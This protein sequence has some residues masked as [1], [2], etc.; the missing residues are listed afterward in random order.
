MD[1]MEGEEI[2]SGL[3]GRGPGDAGRGGRTQGALPGQ[4]QERRAGEGDEGDP[5]RPVF[6]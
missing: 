5:E 2:A 6:F 4:Q 1:R 3:G